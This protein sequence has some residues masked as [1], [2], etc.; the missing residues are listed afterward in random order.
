MLLTGS[1][2]LFVRGPSQAAAAAASEAPLWR[3]AGKV[4][5]P[6]LGPWLNDRLHARLGTAAPFADREPPGDERRGD[7]RASID[8]ALALADDEADSGAPGRALEWLAAAEAIEGL[9]PPE[10]VAK[11]RRWTLGE[12]K[13]VRAVGETW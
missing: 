9:L 12:P 8:L 6:Y 1:L 3:P 5:A 10:Y 7:R 13:A 11:R 4:A 2:P